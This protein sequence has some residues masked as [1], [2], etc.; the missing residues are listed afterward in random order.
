VFDKSLEAWF[1]FPVLLNTSPICKNPKED[2]AF[3]DKT[4]S[5]T[6]QTVKQCHNTNPELKDVF[7]SDNI[8]SKTHGQL[9]P[10][11]QY[12]LEAVAGGEKL[13]SQ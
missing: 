4:S 5:E 12:S 11:H 9:F 13:L 2:L 7:K 3:I 6:V 1:I 8:F 10:H